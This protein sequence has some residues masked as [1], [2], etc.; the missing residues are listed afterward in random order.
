[1]KYISTRGSFQALGF[2]DVLLRGLADDGGL[3]VPEEWPTFSADDIRA[4]QG[5]PYGEVAFRVMQP[6]VGGAISDNDFRAMIDAAYAGF[7]HPAV[8]PLVQ[9]GTNEWILELHRGPTL[10]FK[11]VAMQLLGRLIDHVLS[12]RQSRATIVCATSG[13]TGG[14]AVDA[15]ATRE[16]AD[17]F[18]LLPKGR[19]SDVQ[20]RMMTTRDAANVYAL[21]I[22]GNFDDCQAIVKSMFAHKSFRDAVA[23]SGVNSIN[24]ARVMAQAVYYFVASLALGG[25]DR[26]LS[27]T[28]PT[29]N[30]GDIFAGYVAKR[31]GL[32]IER[33]VIATNSND[34]LA[35]TF[36]AGRHEKTGV[37]ATSSPS[38]DIQ[39]SSNF[40]RLLFDLVGRDAAVVQRLMSGLNQSGSFT[41]PPEALA[42]L[43]S[44]FDASSA[45]EDQTA[46]TIREAFGDQDMLL[47]PHTAVALHVARQQKASAAETSTPMV[48]LS[49][50]HAAKFPDAVKAASGVYPGLPAA[51]HGLMDRT[52]RLTSLPN[53]SAAVEAFIQKQSRITGPS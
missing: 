4:L 24:W 52:E 10:A 47:D 25:P 20:R 16:R 46:A 29:G 28:V 50:A 17:L 12:K 21:E 2:E 8:T 38:M 41:M 53:D 45:S 3:F 1:M 43:R 18:V 49:T 26:K 13:D 27:F 15:F 6:F 32:P 14:A 42:G 44:E 5:Q 22:D 9:S 7:T 31:M 23:L 37:A 34:I 36:E 30:F 40:E 19:V 35:R 39:V 48:V 33:L 11:D 51:H